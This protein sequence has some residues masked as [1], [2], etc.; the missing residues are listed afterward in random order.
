MPN[1][2]LAIEDVSH[3]YRQR[4][5]S[6]HALSNIN[7][8]VEQGEFVSIVGPSGCGKTTLLSL[9]AGTVPVDHGRI[10]LDEL[11]MSD[12]P[13]ENKLALVFQDT[14]LLPWRT[15]FENMTL[16]FELANTPV[17]TDL[18]E[19]TLHLVQ[20]EQFQKSYPHELSGGMRSRVAIARA[21]L[22]RPEI[23]LMDEPF[24]A[25]DEVTAL[26]LNKELLSIW[27]QN[28]M[29][30]LFVTHS[31]S[32]AVFLSSRIVILSSRPGTITREINVDLPYPRNDETLRSQR[33]VELMYDV[34]LYLEKG[35]N[36]E[37]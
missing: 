23:L 14:V 5:T 29:S 6:T 11:S 10:T 15:V 17:N 33:Y 35:S 8:Q 34:R 3:T 31:V 28:K 1:G 30:V 2:L 24:G 12:A 16:P 32:Q 7:L 4:G 37:I 36:Q 13:R 27:R 22:L 21:L 18:I 9:V 25:L 26:H 19:R 20:L